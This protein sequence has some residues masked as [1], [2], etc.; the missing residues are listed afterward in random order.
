MPFR[1]PDAPL[2]SGELEEER[3]ANSA[4]SVLGRSS[5]SS[6]TRRDVDSLEYPF[7]LA[8]RREL[9][10]VQGEED[11]FAAT[12]L[13]VLLWREVVEAQKNIPGQRQWHA[14]SSSS[15]RIRVEMAMPGT[16]KTR[17]GLVH[18]DDWI[19]QAL[20]FQG[21]R[22]VQTGL[23]QIS[24]M[25]SA[26]LDQDPEVIGTLQANLDAVNSAAGGCP[27]FLPLMLAYS[28]HLWQYCACE[29][30]I[31]FAKDLALIG[32][33]AD[34]FAWEIALALD[35]ETDKSMTA[36]LFLAHLLGRRRHKVQLNLYDLSRGIADL[37]SRWRIFENLD[38]V[39]HSGIVVFGSEYFYC[40]ELVYDVP[41]GTAFGTPTKSICLGQ[42]L[43]RVE[44]LHE[45]CVDVLRPIFNS[46][47]YDALEHNCNHY[48]DRISVFLCGKHLP[49]DILQQSERIFKAPM[50]KLMWPALGEWFSSCTSLTSVRSCSST[51]QKGEELERIYCHEPQRRCGCQMCLHEEL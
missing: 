16:A 10:L 36:D 41:S 20:A 9:A 35:L 12:D 27:G 7:L 6:C 50:L 13:L 19:H 15:L 28:R 17:E 40:G 44:E 25:L 26:A 29:R 39:W 47:S 33:S 5:S 32:D 24:S 46:M 22:Q 3:Y 23:Q 38:G 30:G 42:T 51:V 34:L 45:F 21:L 8:L 31:H 11:P 4:S 48:A 18:I 14:G 43:R 37:M 2:V 1:Q 49:A